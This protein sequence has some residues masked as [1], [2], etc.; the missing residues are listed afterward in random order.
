M[1]NQVIQGG[2]SAKNIYDNVQEHGLKD[3]LKYAK[4]SDIRKVGQL[5][6]LGYS[7]YQNNM[8]RKSYLQNSTEVGAT[9]DNTLLK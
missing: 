1:G 8:N 3:G 6:A 9:P 7:T 2:V 5:G 4:L